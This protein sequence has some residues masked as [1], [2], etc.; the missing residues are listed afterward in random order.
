ML[1]GGKTRF[2]ILEALAEA[3][4]PVTAYQIAMTKGLDPAATYRCLTEFLELGIVIKSGPKQR[5]QT[6]YTLSEGTGKAAAVLLRLLKQKEQQRS[7]SMDLEEWLSPEMQV[8]RI[9]K[10]V[11]LDNKLINTTPS[12]E[13]SGRKPGQ[14]K[15]VKEIMSKRVSGELSA[16][17]T[18]SQIAF[19]ELF[20]RKQG[21]FIL[22]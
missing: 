10:I 13:R 8:E 4:K 14:K 20:K 3:K 7:K 6:L 1:L 9:A 19:D 12:P 17:I 22:R 16:L 15:E 2:A 5:N 21:T 18:S 11:R